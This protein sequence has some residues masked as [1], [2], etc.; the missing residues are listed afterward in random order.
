MQIEENGIVYK[1]DKA[2]K[3][4]KITAYRATDIYEIVIPPTIKTYTG[5]NQNIYNVTEIADGALQYTDIKKITLPATIVRIGQCAFMGS[6]ISYVSWKGAFSLIIDDSA[7]ANCTELVNVEFSGIVKLIGD[8]HFVNCYKLEEIDSCNIRGRIGQWSFAQCSKLYEF[9]L[10]DDV[11]VERNSFENTNFCQ[12]FIGN[13]VKISGEV[14]HTLNT[15]NILCN[16]N[17]DILD[18]AYEG[19]NV[20]VIDKN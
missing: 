1:L 13:N 19:Y 4:A 8:N 9:H 17:S 6:E 15:I 14:K 10:S 18:L 2:N 12:M 3:T 20:C 5:F 7:F 16:A 11:I